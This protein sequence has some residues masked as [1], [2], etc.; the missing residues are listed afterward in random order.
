MKTEIKETLIWR[1]IVNCKKEITFTYNKKNYTANY[2]VSEGQEVI[3]FCSLW[4]EEKIYRGYF[5]PDNTEQISD[6]NLFMY[7]EEFNE[8]F[9][10]DSKVVY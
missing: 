6:D 8:Y 7:E 4:K 5:M 10:N 2:T 1:G 9:N 3:F